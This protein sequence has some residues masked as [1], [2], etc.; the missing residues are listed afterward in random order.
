[1]QSTPTMLTKFESKSS[2][3]KGI[4]FH[5]KRSVNQ[6]CPPPPLATNMKLVHGS[7]SPSIPLQYSYGIIEWER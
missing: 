2:R 6:R 7:S 1:M 4:A 5:P 3:A